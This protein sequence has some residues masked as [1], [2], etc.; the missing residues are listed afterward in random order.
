MGQHFVNLALVA[1][2]QLDAAHPELVIYES[3]PSGHLKLTGV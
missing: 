1:D 2:G 3:L